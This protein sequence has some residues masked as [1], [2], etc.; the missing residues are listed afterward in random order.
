MKDSGRT[1]ADVEVRDAAGVAPGMG[2]PRPLPCLGA[3]DTTCPGPRKR[4]ESI[5]HGMR[6]PLPAGFAQAPAGKPSRGIGDPT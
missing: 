3:R 1:N 2:A 6:L 5:H 4:A